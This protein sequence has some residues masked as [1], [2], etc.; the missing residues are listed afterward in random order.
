MH[1]DGALISESELLEIATEEAMLPG[2]EHTEEETDELMVGIFGGE[3]GDPEQ[4]E[5]VDYI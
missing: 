2:S 5:Q 1:G 4:V 3:S